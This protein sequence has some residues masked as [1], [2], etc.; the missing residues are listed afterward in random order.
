MTYYYNDF[1]DPISGIYKTIMKRCYYN[2]IRR[3]GITNF[4]KRRRKHRIMCKLF[5]NQIQ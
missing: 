5:N 3:N 2:F 4:K 1:D